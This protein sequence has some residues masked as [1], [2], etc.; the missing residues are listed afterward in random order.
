[1]SID[2]DARRPAKCHARFGRAGALTGALALTMAA[3]PS[4]SWGFDTGVSDDRVSLPDGPGT[5]EGVGDNVSVDPNMG[6]MRYSVPVDVPEG[7]AGM[8]PSLAFSYSSGGGSSTLGMGWLMATPS[9]ERM[10]M[11]GVPRYDETDRFVADGGNELVR[12]SE[13]V[14]AGEPAIYR[15]RFESDFTR[16]SWHTRAGGASGYWQAEYAD[17]RIA[18][19]GADAEGRAVSSAIEAGAAG[20][21]KYHLVEMVDV[22]GHRIRYAYVK[23]GAVSLLSEIGYV[24]SGASPTYQVQLSYEGRADAVSDA[25]PGFDSILTRRLSG[26]TVLSRGRQL[27]RY[28]LSYED[29]A[30]SG[31]RSRLAKV[32]TFGANDAPYPIVHSFGYSRGLGAQCEDVDCGQ[33]FLTTMVG[34]EGLGVNLQSGTANLVDI[35]GDALPDLVDAS[36]TQPRHRFFLNQLASNG[37]HTFSSPTTSAIGEVSAFALGNPRVQFID[38]NGDGFTDLLSG[39]TTDQKVLLN[40]GAGDWVSQEDLPGSS[41]WTG[42]DA[43]LRFMDYDND[44]DVDLIRSTA[45]ETFVFDNDGNF[46]FTR[47]DLAPLGVAFSES[48]QFTDM[49]GDGLLDVVQL[50]SG[51][52]LFKTNFGRGR[53]AS[54]WTTLAHPFVAGE[55]ERAL[56]E[57]LDSDGYADLVVATGNTVKYVLNRNGEGFEPLRTLSEAGGASLPNVESTTTVLAADMNGNGSVDIVWI[58]ANGSVQYLDLFPVRSHLLTRIE[59]GIGRVTTIVYQPSVQQLALSLEEGAPWAHPL[60][61]PMTVVSQTDEFDLLTNV[62]DVVDFRYRDG[63]YDGV[64]RQFRGYAEVLQRMDGDE[65]HA[66]GRVLSRYD[67]GREAPHLNGQL[68]YER[69]ESDGEVIDETTSVFGDAA[70]CPVAEVPTNARLIALGRK[71]IGFACEVRTET[72]IQEGADASEWVTTRTRMTYEDGYGNVA[73]ASEDGVVAVGGGACPACSRPD[74]GFG[75]PCGN[76]CLGDERFVERTYVPVSG[77]GGRWLL[78]RVA[79]ETRFGVESGGGQFAEEIFHYDGEAFVGLP[80]GQLTQGKLTRAVSRVGNGASIESVRQ[81]FDGHGNAVET[82]DPNGTLGGRSHRREYTYDDEGLKVVQVEAFNEGPDGAPYRLRR[83][84]QHHELFDAVVLASSWMVVEGQTVTTAA[85]PTS[86]T[87]DAFGRVESF[88]LPGGDTGASPSIELEYDLG[89]P[90]TRLVTRRRSKV[91]GPLD[92]ETIRCADGRGRTYQT[93]RKVSDGEYIVDGFTL[94][95]LRSEPVKVFQSYTSDSGQCD[96]APPANVRATTYHYDGVSRLVA[97][98]HPDADVAGGASVER[99]SYA[100]LRTSMCDGEDTDPASLHHDTPDTQ[101]VDGLGR[102]VATERRLVGEVAVTRIEYDALGFIAGY[103]DAMGHTKQQTFDALGRLLTVKDPNSGTTTFTYDD[104]GNVLSRVDGRGVAVAYTYDGLNREIAR[105]DPADRE[106]TLIET[107]WDRSPVCDVARCPNTAGLMVAR[108]YP[109]GADFMGYDVRRRPFSAVR[110]IEGQTYTL[111]T[112][113]DNA[114]RA[115]QRIFP[116]GRTLNYDYDSASRVVSIPGVVS[117]V[118]YTP[119]G[120]MESLVR[121]NQVVDGLRY[122]P[123]LRLSGVDVTAKSGTLLQTLEVVHDRASNVSNVRDDAVGALMPSTAYTYDAWYRSNRIARGAKVETMAFDL[124]DGLRTKDGVEYTYSG[125][126]P[127]AP[128]AVGDRTRSYDDAGDVISSDGF[129]HTWDFQGRLVASVSADTSVRSV[130]GA[131]HM[132]LARH[133]DGQVT[134]YVAQDFEVRDGISVIYPRISGVRVARLESADYASTWLAG[135]GEVAEGQPTAAVAYTKLQADEAGHQA[136]LVAAARRMLVKGR[137]AVVALHRDHLGSLALATGEDGEVIGRRAF[138]TFGAPSASTGFVDRY[139]F[140]G[141]EHEPHT[142]LLRF[143]HRSLA[144][145]TGQWM[146]P[147]PAFRAV[148]GEEM[149]RLPEAIARYAYVLNNPG[150]FVDPDGLSRIGRAFVGVKR[151]IARRLGLGGSRAQARNP[152]WGVRFTRD[153][154]QPAGDAGRP[155]S[156]SSAG[157]SLMRSLRSSLS[158]M[159]ESSLG[160]GEGDFLDS[161]STRPPTVGHYSRGWRWPSVSTLDLNAPPANDVQSVA[162]QNS[163][164]NSRHSNAPS[165]FTVSSAGSS[166]PPQWRWAGR[167][168]GPNVRHARRF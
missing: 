32:Q 54:E 41:V 137:P 150:T 50:Q 81:R 14:G 100:P 107:A 88:L 33:P 140:T 24:F 113:Y 116:D 21:F 119:Q 55:F 112:G 141:Q 92:I 93:R 30:V 25:K 72:V 36:T 82:L 16:Y 123:R 102:L 147:D 74:G 131:D 3:W 28:A 48:I 64:E 121:P 10:T 117:A 20:T 80:E 164:R 68:L 71:P 44:M 143:A 29:E 45:T 110:V 59:N 127:G 159:S 145:Q 148:T 13:S 133:D 42:A 155:R 109:A 39:G 149:D 135:A 146:S 124:I 47:R 60:P 157:R 75:A 130:Y 129:E 70:E 98:E 126:R 156:R 5:L 27:R 9:I 69:R 35:N 15:A 2:R 97:V 122:D 63:F 162:S 152:R 61:Y 151:W 163:A 46:G 90:S 134:H 38:V 132:R 57:D 58:G 139:G 166:V 19:F 120:L 87:Y 23:D 37:A 8:T 79:R 95:N 101:V 52:L 153:G 73:K 94:F 118:N 144:T 85:D 99:W 86:Y 34:D 67:V 12:V 62:H 83:T 6:L 53:F 77:T 96:D 105:F 136:W 165:A 161:P 78:D 128:S 66:P 106:G 31:R 103:V 168:D 76:Q 114:D 7:F 40:R 18:Y 1:M 125:P 43:E 56:V 104:V 160:D 91:G 4:L 108:S 158:G 142:G 89:N 138:D 26:V 17:G 111:Q 65:S 115:V 11:R 167:F 154:D 22:Y 49:N 51:Q 84:F